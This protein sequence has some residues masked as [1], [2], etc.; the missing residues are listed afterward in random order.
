MAAYNTRVKI[1]ISSKA[2]ADADTVAGSYAK[3]L[4][5]FIQSLDSSSGEIQQ[6]NTV[7]LQNGSIMTIL[8]YLG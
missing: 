8:V 3:E 5:D 7:E 4:N 2:N 1:F 6:M